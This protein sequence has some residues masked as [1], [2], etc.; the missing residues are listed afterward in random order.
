MT[1]GVFD[2]GYGGLTVVADILRALPYAKIVYVGDN[3]RVPYGNKSQKT[4]IEYSKQISNFLISKNVD[5]IVVACNTASSVALGAVKKISKIPVVG[6]IEPVID[7]AVNF[8]SYKKI[9]VIG[10]TGTINSCA[11]E[12]SIH[13]INKKIRVVSLACPLFVPLIEEGLVDHKITK[14]IAREYLSLKL[15]NIDCLILGCTHYPLIS[16]MI[17][18]IVG[19]KVKL[20]TCGEP[21]AREIGKK[22]GSVGDIVKGKG[23]KAKHEFYTTD[24]IDKFKK[25]GSTF[26][27]YKIDKVKKLSLDKF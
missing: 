14:I 8:L 6:M 12:K 9:G 27:G 10:T 26:L 20:L 22:I 16:E 5:V 15:K 2:S 4:I 21:A 18:K 17:Q 7:E 13:K 25:M 11:Y 19:K 3:A 1:I 23:R 24:D